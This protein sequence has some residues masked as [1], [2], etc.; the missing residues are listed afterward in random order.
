MRGEI[1]QENHVKTT[2]HQRNKKMV[3]RKKTVK[4]QP[5]TKARN[6][7]KQE[8]ADWAQALARATTDTATLTG[9]L[10]DMILETGSKAF[11]QTLAKR[12]RKKRS[13]A[14]R[15]TKLVKELIESGI[16][17]VAFDVLI[18]NEI[19][20]RLKIRFGLAFLLLT[21]LFTA[22]SYSIVIFDGIYGWQISEV[23]ITALIIETPIQF[24]GLLYIIAR[25]LFPQRTEENSNSGAG[26]VRN[27]NQHQGTK[28]AA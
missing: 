10:M 21:F 11:P 5:L 18:S 27:K 16:D 24:I 1:S 13:I 9:P 6:A 4:T 14:E 20:R 7:K 17:P 25:N 22:A 28:S 2:C 15:K 23:A 12:A 26:A 19:N 3:K 8:K